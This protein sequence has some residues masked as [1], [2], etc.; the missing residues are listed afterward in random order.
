V[1]TLY[2]TSLF[3]RIGVLSAPADLYWQESLAFIRPT[4]I[5]IKIGLLLNHLFFTGPT[6][7]DATD[8]GTDDTHSCDKRME[9]KIRAME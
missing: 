3:L 8:R 7:P 4:L 2:A 9:R 6:V 1:P 5:Y